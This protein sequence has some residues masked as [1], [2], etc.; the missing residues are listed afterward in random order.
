[1]KQVL[2]KVWGFLDAYGRMRAEKRVV[3]YGWY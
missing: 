1:M 2:T 3:R